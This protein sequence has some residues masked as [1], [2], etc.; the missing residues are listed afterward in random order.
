MPVFF[1]RNAFVGSDHR[2]WSEW[3]LVIDRASLAHI[4]TF[5]GPPYG[6]TYIALTHEGNKL[7]HFNG[8]QCLNT[9]KTCTVYL[10]VDKMYKAEWIF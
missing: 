9:R 7:A 8:S 10:H 4:Q 3:V 2:Q 1:L 5:L 6:P